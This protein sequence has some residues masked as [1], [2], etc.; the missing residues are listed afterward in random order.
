LQIWEGC[1]IFSFKN[2]EKS[3]AMHLYKKIRKLT[4]KSKV[5]TGVIDGVE[6]RLAM[7]GMSNSLPE[8][9]HKND[10]REDLQDFIL[11]PDGFALDNSCITEV[12]WTK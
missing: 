11:T 6:S 8:E 9:I 4:R 10:L 1:C 5:I 7:L 3:H 2:S 12:K